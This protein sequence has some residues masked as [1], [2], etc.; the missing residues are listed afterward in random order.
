[1]PNNDNLTLS[2]AWHLEASEPCRKAPCPLLPCLGEMWMVPSDVSASQCIP[3]ISIEAVNVSRK[4]VT[5]LLFRVLRWAQKQKLTVINLTSLKLLQVL[6]IFTA[7]LLH[8]NKV[9]L[10]GSL[11]S[12]WTQ[13]MSLLPHSE[14]SLSAA[15]TSL[16]P[17]PELSFLGG[18]IPPLSSLWRTWHGLVSWEMQKEIEEQHSSKQSGQQLPGRLPCS[19]AHM[20][21]MRVG[22]Q[23]PF[24]LCP[25][26]KQSRFSSSQ[27]PA[28]S[29]RQ[30]KKKQLA[31]N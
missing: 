8:L 31:V 30:K 26:W 29:V 11:T 17:S 25:V 13:P 7:P 16:P 24:W 20:K 22:Q 6:Y 28:T 1:M 18:Y 12:H 19:K 15:F 4:L 27:H 23:H 14:V 10:N 2:M 21:S 3:I 9:F 5:W